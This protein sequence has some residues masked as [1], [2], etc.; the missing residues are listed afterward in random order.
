VDSKYSPNGTLSTVTM[1][2]STGNKPAFGFNLGA[3]V[4]ALAETGEAKILA[5]PRILS[6]NN[7]PSAILSG[8]AVPIFTSVVV[9]GA[10]GTIVNQQVQYINVGVSLQILPRIAA[11]GRVTTQIFCECRASSTTSKT[12]R[13]S[14]YAKSSR[15]PS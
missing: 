7:R 2:V 3:A 12:R 6:L 5:R 15:R 11:D 14:P 8:E 13:A 1:G 9:P 4:N 10:T